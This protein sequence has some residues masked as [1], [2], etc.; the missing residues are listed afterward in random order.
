MKTKTTEQL[1]REIR[2]LKR[3]LLKSRKENERLTQRIRDGE[4]QLES[5]Y[6]DISAGEDRIAELERELERE[7]EI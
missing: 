1:Q 3:E 7:K 5:A 2:R 6:E 4:S